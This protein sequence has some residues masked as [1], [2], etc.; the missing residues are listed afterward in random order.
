M[1]TRPHLGRAGAG[2]LVVVA[3]LALSQATAPR[4]AAA[5]SA[6]PRAL[7][8]IKHPGGGLFEHLHAG[9]EALPALV[10]GQGLAEDQSR[11]LAVIPPGRSAIR[12]PILMYH[13]IRFNPDP[14]DQLGFNLSVT[15]ADFSSQMDWLQAN[16]FHPIDFNDLRAYFEGRTGLPARPV[17][18]TFD[19]GY[20]DVYT[21]AFPILRAHHFK[22]VAYIV[23]GFIGSDRNVSADMVREMDAGGVE[24]ASHTVSH[25]DLTRTPQPELDRQL[26]ESKQSLEQLLGRPVLDFCYPAG[27]V[28]QRV[29]D[30]VAA[31]GYATATT[32]VPG[33]L[34]SLADRFRW[35]RIRV[36][37]GEGLDRFA[38]ELTAEEPSVVM[39]GVPLPAPAPRGAAAR[40]VFPLRF[41]PE[42]ALA[43]PGDLLLP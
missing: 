35:T 28:D 10:A 25:V 21:A 17:V 26:R 30:A 41:L 42:P 36:S 3:V 12:V 39:A 37:G 9:S 34:H 11:P 32:T 31:A 5:L 16:G 27:A 8:T 14:R 29:V 24:I 4:T 23:S 7:I 22:A 6:Q 1:S 40:V 13:Y 15:P 38:A 19:D 43:Q 2:A 20:R 18:L 33:G